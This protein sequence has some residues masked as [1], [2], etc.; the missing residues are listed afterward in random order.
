M[1]KLSQEILD[2]EHHS[3]VLEPSPELRKQWME[4]VLAYTDSFID[5]MEDNKAFIDQYHDENP[6]RNITFDK[7]NS[8]EDVLGFL[9]ENVDSKG[10]NPASGGHVGYIPG[11][12]IYPTAMGDFLAAVTNRYAG[13][14]F[15]GPGAVQLENSLIQ[16]MC[17]IVG[18]PPNAHGNLSSGGSI[19]NLIAITTARDKKEI[20][21]RK[22]D[23]SVI[24]VTNQTHH[25]VQKAI[26][27]AGLNESKLRYITMDEQ[28]KM[29][30]NALTNQIKED[31]SN[32]LNPFLI[33][34]SAGTTDT[35]SIDPLNKMADIAAEYNCW[36]H[37]DAAY[38]GFFVLVD[39]LKE[40][41]KGMDRADSL[42]I[43]PH[44]GL[45]LSYGLGV[46][47]I[48][49]VKAMYDSHFYKAGYMQDAQERFDEISPA[50]VSPELT[51]HFRGLRL[52]LSLR[53]FGLD[54]FIKALT[55][56][57]KLAIYFHREIEKLGFETGAEPELSVVLY[58]YKHCED[59]NEFNRLLTEEIHKD[60][61]VF[62]SSTVL[63][64][65]NWMRA[66][67]LSFRTHKRTIDQCLEMIN[68]CV[69]R[70]KVRLTQ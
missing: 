11:G 65:E 29:D 48:K 36:F 51:K 44:K 13:I 60:G 62:L 64:G 10:L 16:W 69:E 1:D 19:A 26:R 12:G 70:V 3:S 52:W 33:V 63:N 40:R 46:I 57:H 28:F 9:K 54:P 14:F 17:K 66:A 55:E 39:E 6:F 53:L 31:I 38:G 30:T 34:G 41:F 22:V 42:A 23:S 21:S 32:G 50:D 8:I 2:L 18:F 59:K 35:G 47:L 61:R 7:S 43:D 68:D 56:K 15:G 5:N 20:T 37:V 58:R 25:C 27:I 24:Y 49:D 45:F 4:K 67:I